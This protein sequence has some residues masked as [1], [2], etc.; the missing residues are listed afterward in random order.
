MRNIKLIIEYDG[1]D[2][3]GWQSQRS[4]RTIQDVLSE[5]ILALTGEK[6]NLI[7]AGR[8]D[9]GVHALGQVASFKTE[10]ALEATIIKRALNATLPGDIAVLDASDADESFNA[11]HSASGKTYFYNILSNSRA[12]VFLRRYAWGISG[13]IDIDAMAGAGEFLK[14]KMDF[15]AMRGA[16]CGAKTTVREVYELKVE[17]VK[18]FGF[19]TATF[20]GDLI[21]ITLTA[22]AFLRHMVRNIVGTLVD[23]GRGRIP[24]SAVGGIVESKDRRHAGATA[25]PQGLFLEKVIYPPHLSSF[26]MASMTSLFS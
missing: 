25:P 4:G 18:E 10:S 14:G 16:G 6:P 13:K 5:R 15:S 19:F 17:L 9:A 26:S 1:T 20:G 2:Y 23:A 11:R 12:P 21:K 8:T 7:A 24:P 3:E 22:D